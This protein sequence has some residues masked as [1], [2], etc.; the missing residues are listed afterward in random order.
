[1]SGLASWLLAPLGALVVAGCDGAKASHSDA[2][3]QARSSASVE[4]P[5]MPAPVADAP[6]IEAGPAGPDAAVSREERERAVLALLAGGEPANR[7]P[8]AAVDPGH[9]FDPAQRDRAAPPWRPPVVKS[10][11]TTVAGQ[12]PVEVFDR[13]VR[14]NMG[15]FRLCYEHGLSTNPELGGE[16]VVHLVIDKTGSVESVDSPSATLADPAVVACVVRGFGNL[17]FPE[18]GNKAKVHVKQTLL[19]ESSDSP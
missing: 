15:R 1:M 17:T 7:L 9:D 8:R 10:R 11:G 4:P 19:F 12:L 14:Q 5:T 3:P 6:P 13:I 18:P 16:I 2:R